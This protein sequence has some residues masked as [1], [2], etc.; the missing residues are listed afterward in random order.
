MEHLAARAA[1][2]GWKAMNHPSGHYSIGIFGAGADWTP[3]LAI[4]TKHNN[5]RKPL[6]SWEAMAFPS[7]QTPTITF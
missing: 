7:M 5:F 6:M 3:E 4:P 2:Q 1:A